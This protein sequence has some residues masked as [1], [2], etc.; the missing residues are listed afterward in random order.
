MARVLGSTLIGGKSYLPCCSR[1]RLWQ[2]QSD[3]AGMTN[4]YAFLPVILQVFGKPTWYRVCTTPYLARRHT[5]THAASDHL[6]YSRHT[7]MC[8]APMCLGCLVCWLNRIRGHNISSLSLP[9][10]RT[11]ALASRTY[12]FRQQ[13][14]SLVQGRP[15]FPSWYGA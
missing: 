3:Q 8:K 12:N 10:P 2:T 4:D 14:S 7:A 11:F 15:W 9:A 13:N 1:P 6:D 5:H